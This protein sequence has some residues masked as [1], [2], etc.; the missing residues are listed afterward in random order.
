MGMVKSLMVVESC[1]GI[2][3]SYVS[4]IPSVSPELKTMYLLLHMISSL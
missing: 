2:A 4:L 1:T 3:G